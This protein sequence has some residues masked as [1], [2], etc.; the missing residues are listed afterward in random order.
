M[1]NRGWEGQGGMGECTEDC[2]DYVVCFFN[3]GGEV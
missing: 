2:V 3:G 1:V